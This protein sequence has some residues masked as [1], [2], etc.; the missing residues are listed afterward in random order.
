MAE[1]KGTEAIDRPHYATHLAVDFLF[2]QQEGSLELSPKFQRRPIWKDPAKAYFIDTLLRGFPVP[3]LYM[4]RAAQVNRAGM[5]REV[6]DGQQRLRAL[7]EFFDGDL[8][9]TKSPGAPWANKSLYQLGDEDL[10][11]LQRFEFMVVEYDQVPDSTVLEIFSRLNTYSVGLNSQELRNGRWF[12]AFK[13]AVYGLALEYLEF[14]R[15]LSIFTEAAIARMAE[16]QLISELLILQMDG[17]QDK[18]ASLNT[19]YEHLDAKW[20]GAEKR[21]R[22]RN[23]ELPREW[24][25][26]KTAVSRVRRVLDTIGEEV[27]PVLRDTRFRR[28]PLFYTLYAAVYHRYYG[29]PGFERPSPR[30]PLTSD[31]WERLGAALW[32]LSNL[33][34]PGTQ[35]DDLTGWRREFVEASARQTDNIGPR[36]RRLE[37]LWNL[38]ELSD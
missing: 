7:L 12:G 19:Y 22:F 14:W 15:G 28:A 16:A 30:R 24:L 20:G 4:R 34:T 35:R 36:Q 37:I 27:G 3:P 17:M 2:W 11:R 32:D 6:I 10:E 31:G 5:V 8:K 38:G 1:R 33:L 21:W 13:T 23:R 18:K 25:S 26:E 9:L 29:L